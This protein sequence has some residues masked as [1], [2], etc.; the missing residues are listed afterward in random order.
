MPKEKLAEEPLTL[1]AAYE[2]LRVAPAATDAQVK[3]AF[4]KRMLEVHPD[5]H[6]GRELEAKQ[7]NA[8]R[9]LIEQARRNGWASETAEPPPPPAWQPPQSRPRPAGTRQT[10]RYTGNVNAFGDEEVFV[11][12]SEGTETRVQGPNERAAYE[13]AA[14]AERLRGVQTS[15]MRLVWVEQADGTLIQVYVPT[16]GAWPGV[17]F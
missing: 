11:E 5:R 10:P 6:P 1:R 3:T 17:I 15:G 7:L 13:A 12:T 9:D 8:A 14:A 4:R 16:G 2:L